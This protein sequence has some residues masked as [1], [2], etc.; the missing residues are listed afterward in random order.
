MAEL[1]RAITIRNIVSIAK[2]KNIKIGDI[3]QK[4]GV[5]AG[6]LS[7]LAKDDNKGVLS[8]DVIYNIANQ[9]ETS[10]DLL[11]STDPEILSENEN[12]ILG[13]LD[14]LMFDTEHSSIEWKMMPPMIQDAT[15]LVHDNPLFRVG[16]ASAEDPDGNMHYYEET[17]YD[18]RFLPVNCGVVDGDCFHTIIDDSSG[19]EIYVMKVRQRTNM[20]CTSSSIENIIEIYFIRG[21]NVEPII[22]TVL[23]CE[24]LEQE[25]RRLYNTIEAARSHL[26]IEPRTKGIIERYAKKGGVVSN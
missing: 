12:M 8:I 2:E 1:N 19:T 26:S 24:Q 20:Y 23:A 16:D 14:K 15:Y 18:S 10:I 3:E 22:C 25:I 7:R 11:V 9:L 21:D 13:F 4:A 5:S 17:S 6:Y